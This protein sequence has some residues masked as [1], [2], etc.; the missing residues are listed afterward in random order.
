MKP[1]QADKQL[2]I[3]FA[4]SEA[5]PFVKTGGLADVIGTLPHALERM[6]VDARV[7]LPKYRDIPS[8]WLEQMDHVCDFQINIGWRRQYCGIEHIEY[9]NVHYYFI[10]NEFYFARDSIYGESEA[11]GERFGFFSKAIIECMPHIGFFPDILHCNDWQTGLAPVLL[12]LHYKHLP[13]FAQVRT[14]FSI[15]NLKYQGVFDW[16]MID[17]LFGIGTRYFSPEYLEFYGGVSFMKGGIVF[18]DHLSTVS[19]TYAQEIQF[20]YYGEQ[21]DGLLRARA[22]NLT[23][24]LNGIDKRF[25]NPWMDKHIAARYSKNDPSGKALCKAALQKE[26]GLPVDEDAV[27]VAMVSRL[28]EQKGFDLL[29]RV[30]DEMLHL[31]IQLVVV[32]TGDAHYQ[33]MLTWAQWRYHGKVS[34]R[35]E[36]N[37][38]LS[39]RAYAGADIFLMPSRFEPCGL[40]QLIALRYGAVP[41]VRETG[42]LKD[43]V[44]PYNKYTDEGTGFS[45]ANYNAH[46]MLFTLEQALKYFL[47]RKLWT[48]L[49]KRGM[50]CDFGWSASAQKYHDLYM[51]MLHVPTTTA[52]TAAPGAQ[53]RASQKKRAASGQQPAKP[54]K[55]PEK[56]RPKRR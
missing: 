24:I 40:S 9:E 54:S 7:V 50:S 39:H 51:R 21:L 53:A 16:Q 6:G 31:P 2:K 15:H 47:D 18:A 25:W 5:L 22:D 38:E 17:G 35:M 41:L 19:P 30:L 3:L 55:T 45:F 13:D 10:D 27:V 48:R 46:E 11:E 4:A 20:P 34:V 37:E 42:G 56:G 1:A 33:E 44:R 14:L 32:G 12:K 29:E 43:T 26:F 36:Y 49:V 52:A 23:G 8:F 28:T